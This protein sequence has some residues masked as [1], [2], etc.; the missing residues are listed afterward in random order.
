M[1]CDHRHLAREGFPLSHH[2]IISITAAVVPSLLLIWYFYSQDRFPEPRRVLL[3]TF[4][5][6]V[7]TTIPAGIVEWILMSQVLPGLGLT[8]L[9][10]GLSMA[11]TAGATEEFFKWLVVI[12]YCARNKEFDEPMDGI[13]YGVVASLG[14]ATLE[15]YIYVQVSP[16]ESM[17][18]TALARAFTAVPCHAFLGAIMGYHVGQAWFGK[19][20]RGLHLL[21]SLVLPAVLHTLYDFPLMMLALPGEQ[22]SPLWFLWLLLGLGTLVLMGIWTMVLVRKLRA[23]QDKLPGPAP[24]PT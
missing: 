9:M 14:F 17:L 21:L 15:N 10:A 13:V 23:E 3:M 11:G 18:M 8:N 12:L 1:P 6:G 16:P 22:D 24:E 19:G 7:L 20:G 5:L 2:L 4:F